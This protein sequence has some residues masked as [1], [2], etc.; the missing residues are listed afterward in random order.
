MA[1]TKRAN[2]GRGK[3]PRISDAEW[4]VMKTLWNR[5]PLTTNQ[6]V[7]TLQPQT[8]WQPKTIHTLLRRLVNKGALIFSKQGREYLFQ[9]VVQAQDCLRQASRTFLQRLFDGR[10]AA[11]LA[12]LLEEEDLSAEDIAELKR[13]LNDQRP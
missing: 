12:Y 1:R 2:R 6:V 4:L 3:L 13:M 10:A 11:F 8:Q 5:A 9:P 7:E